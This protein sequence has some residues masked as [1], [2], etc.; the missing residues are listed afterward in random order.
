MPSLSVATAIVAG[1][2]LPRILVDADSRMAAI[3]FGGSADGARAVLQVVAGS[4][5]T[6]TGLIFSLTVVALQMASAQFTPR[7]LRTFLSDRGNQAVL[8]VFLATFAYALVVLRTVRGNTE[9]SDGFVPQLAVSVAFLLTLLSVAML[10]YFIHHLTT[11]LRVEEVMHDVRRA[12]VHLIE[13]RLERLGDA[14]RRPELP[15]PPEDAFRVPVHSSGLVQVVEPGGIAS[16]AADADVT[17]V[18]RAGVGAHLTEGTTLAWVWPP[19]PDDDEADRYRRRIQAHVRIGQDPTLQQDVAFGVRQLVDIASKALSPGVNDPTTA[20]TAIQELAVVL[21]AA[22]DRDLGPTVHR[23]GAEGRVTV[24]VPSV[25]FVALVRLACDQ[26]L[27]YGANEP[28][29]ISALL[30]LLTDLAEVVTDDDRRET[31]QRQVSR[32]EERLTD[33]DG[34]SNERVEAA[35][36]AARRAIRAGVRLPSTPDAS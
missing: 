32:I 3:V 8:S 14:P 11:Q 34:E 4:T 18:L 2:L 30:L 29:V 21:A 33:G 17:V 26:P 24:V 12:T 1:L 13:R 36:S 22:A 16:F 27:R 20:V 10:V 9:T 35:V 31:L 28:D 7:V 5:I 6:I 25:D 23:D 15:Q 19:P